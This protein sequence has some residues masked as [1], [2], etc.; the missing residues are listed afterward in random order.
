MEDTPLATVTLAHARMH[1]HIPTHRHTV[2][3]IQ[4]IIQLLAIIFVD[5]NQ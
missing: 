4:V 3:L 1:A 5:D 2:T